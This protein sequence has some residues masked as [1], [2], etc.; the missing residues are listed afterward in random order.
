MGIRL[1]VNSEM[2]PKAVVKAASEQ[3]PPGVRQRAFSSPVDPLFFRCFAVVIH[4]VHRARE[5]QHINQRR[6]RHQHRVNRRQALHDGDRL[7]PKD[8]RQ[9]RD[10]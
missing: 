7:R 8:E 2:R 6:H 4:D 5:T 10:R 3:G 1:L 9:R